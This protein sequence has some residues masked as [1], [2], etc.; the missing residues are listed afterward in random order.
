MSVLAALYVLAASSL[1]AAAVRPTAHSYHMTVTP[2]RMPPLSIYVE[3]MG[4]GPV[5]LMLHGLA[6]SSYTWRALAQRLASRY[7]LIAIDLRGHGRSDKPFDQF[8]SPADHAAVVRAFMRQRGLTDVTIVGHSLGGF[9]SLLL[10]MDPRSSSRISRLVVMSTPAFRQP[11]APAVAL[12]QYPVLPYLTTFFV[13]PELPTAL[14]LYFENAGLVRPHDVSIYSDPLTEPGGPH[15]LI[16]TARQL[17]PPDADEIVRHYQGIRQAV[18]VIHCRHD[19]VVPMTSSL[20]LSRL[21]PRAKLAVLDHC[22]HI[23]PEQ[24]TADVAGLMLSFLGK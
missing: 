11:F 14:A 8:Y 21:L 10:A 18:L 22:Q 23:P 2:E 13:P 17:V 16:S 12:M 4:S 20:R 5:L 9:L 1:P 24:A 19:D 6:A 3:E 7:R 15:A